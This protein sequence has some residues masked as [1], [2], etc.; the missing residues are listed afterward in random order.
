[1][2]CDNWILLTFRA[3][4]SNATKSQ[5]IKLETISIHLLSSIVFEKSISFIRIAFFLL[6]KEDGSHYFFFFLPHCDVSVPCIRLV[7]RK[8]SYQNSHQLAEF[9]HPWSEHLSLSVTK[10]RREVPERQW[11]SLWLLHAT[12][13]PVHTQVTLIL[14]IR[15]PFPERK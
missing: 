3:P 9:I 1:M 12:S 10:M 2:V 4:D 14:R 15:R 6:L 5:I 8:P 11:C 7:V 13:R